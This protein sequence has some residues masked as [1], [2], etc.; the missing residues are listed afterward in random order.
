M[1]HFLRLVKKW[2]FSS[3]LLLYL[4]TVVV[5]TVTREKIG[6]EINYDDGGLGGVLF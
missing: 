4:V 5:G 1:L 3:L 6:L 2:P